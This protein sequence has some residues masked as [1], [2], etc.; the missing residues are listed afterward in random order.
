M[1]GLRVSGLKGLVLVDGDGE[2]THEVRERTGRKWKHP[3]HE[4]GKYAWHT[5]S[6]TAYEAALRS[7]PGKAERSLFAFLPALM[8]HGN[9]IGLS[10]KA[11][12]ERTGLTEPQVSTAMAKLKDLEI[13]MQVDGA[14][15]F[16]PRLAWKGGIPGPLRAAIERWK[17]VSREKQV[18]RARRWRGGQ[19]EP[20]PE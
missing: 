14:Y 15:R 13:V 6:G 16:D 1:E 3:Y 17:E 7:L 12:A 11:M 4:R 5:A 20:A 2:I 19:G 8:E 10:Q 9:E 18:E